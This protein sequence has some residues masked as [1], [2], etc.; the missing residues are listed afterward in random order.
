[1]KERLI[2]F[3]LEVLNQD[4]ASICSIG[5]VEMVDQKVKSTYYSL[6]KPMN[7]SFDSFSYKV[8]QI[9]P[10]SLRNEKTFPEIWEEIKE[11]FQNSLV[12]SHDIQGD[13]YH[14]RADFKKYSM[15][16]PTLHMSCT[17]VLAHLVYPELT[18]YNL[19]D[20][21]EM[22]HYEF[23]AHHAL[24]DAKAT[25][26][27]YQQ[28]LKEKG[29]ETLKE[30]HNLYHLEFGE[31]KTNYYRNM[32]SPEVAPQLLSMVQQEDAFLYHQSI[33][34]TGKLTMPKNILEEKTKD[35]SAIM[36]HQ[37]NMQTNYL[38]IGDRGYLKVRFGKKN[39]KVQ[40]A[41]QL[42]KQGQDI[43]IV[44]EHEYLRMLKKKRV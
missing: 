20:L 37:V 28:M 21:C 17:N 26:F 19:H 25:M 40:K 29:C 6:V 18:K 2:F 5:I 1:M 30:L 11:Y 13:M 3:D 38:V 9:K 23:H 4:P 10:K 34:F 41:L 33:C 44:R 32:I 36:S 43:Q 24:E 35:A 7:L 14:L 16:F 42:K 22:H 12:I 27:L 31:M 15:P 39:K 8:H